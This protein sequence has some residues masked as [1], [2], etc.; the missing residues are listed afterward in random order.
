M[1]QV[2]SLDYVAANKSQAVSERLTIRQATVEDLPLIN[3]IERQTATHPWSSKQL[4][5][6]L[7]QI[8][9]LVQQKQVIGFAVIALIDQQ[10]EL[11]NIAI[12]PDAQ[13]QGFG[14][15]FLSLLIKALPKII[16]QFY[17][18]VRV[19]NYR[20]IRLYHGIG[21]NK[22]GERKDYYRNGLGREDAV[23]MA[24]ACS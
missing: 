8:S 19:G 12:V 6:C 20:A 23:V 15:I 11:H 22:I 9:V 21:F 16:Q 5:D 3:A 13:G 18:E 7:N 10:A 14:S 24:K 2:L 1:R 17:L 4:N